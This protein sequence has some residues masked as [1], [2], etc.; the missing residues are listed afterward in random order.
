MKKIVKPLELATKFKTW[1]DALEYD[2][3]PEYNSSKNE[4]YYSIV[5]N[6]FWLQGGL[7]AFT[8][9]LLVDVETVS[10]DKWKEGVFSKFQFRGQLEHF[11]ASLKKKNGWLWNNFL[12]ADTD[13]NT[14]V[15][16]V[17]RI[18]LLKP[19]K[20]D[21]DPNYYLRYDINEA[22]FYPNL[23]RTNEERQLLLDDIDNLGINHPSIVLYRKKRLNPLLKSI[24]YQ[25]K[26][27]ENIRDEVCE[28][29]TAFEM[30]AIQVLALDNQT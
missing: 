28:Y 14:K 10:P 9:M 8:E 2:N 30:A 29:L 7:C 3:H 5:A 12:M 24:Q 11:D 18:N 21:Y 23:E 19:D 16:G 4:H 20:E 6:L 26:T 22:M 25:E 1:H 13:I 27:F 15:K 17:K